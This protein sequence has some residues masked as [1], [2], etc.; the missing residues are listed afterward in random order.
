ML[1]FS[2]KQGEQIRIGDNIEIVVVEVQGNRVRL[3]FTAPDGVGIHREE[4]FRRM[5]GDRET[6]ERHRVGETESDQRSR[7]PGKPSISAS[8]RRGNGDSA[9]AHQL[10]R[11]APGSKW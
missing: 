6:L 4:V 1:V 9:C 11:Q 3:G 7:F 5:K 2:R 10:S 8:P